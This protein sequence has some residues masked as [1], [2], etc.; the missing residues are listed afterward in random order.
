[1][2]YQKLA[3]LSALIT[4]A[5]P[6]GVA[7]AQVNSPATSVAPAL[8]V[9][10]EQVGAAL[11]ASVATAGSRARVLQLVEDSMIASEECACEIVKSAIIASK[12]DRDFVGEIVRTAATASPGMTPTIAECAMQVAP[13]AAVRIREALERVLVGEGAVDGGKSPVYDGGA[14]MDDGASYGKGEVY[15]KGQ[16]Y[17]KSVVDPGPVSGPGP[18]TEGGGFGDDTWGKA[19]VDIRGIYLIPPAVGGFGGFGGTTEV[20]R[21]I[22]ERDSGSSSRGRTT[23]A[24]VILG[25][26][27]NDSDGDG[28]IDS[29]E[30]DTDQDGDG[31]PAYLDS[32]TDGDG[33]PDSSEGLNDF[34]GD[35]VP[36]F[37][38][39]NGSSQPST[40]TLPP[41]PYSD[42]NCND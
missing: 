13:D 20:V 3:P 39:F 21:E 37:R 7:F 12:A 19:P 6:V 5:L 15:G 10:C 9:A 2:A 42:P 25:L 36:D 24:T 34:D 41:C 33:I 30:G 38:D 29:V 32:D 17:G 23:A 35:G 16:V 1:M 31:I 4:L 22:V 11:Q 26:G 8:E 40:P 28:I 14:S 27:G 18:V